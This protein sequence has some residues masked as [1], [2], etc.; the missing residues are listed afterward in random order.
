MNARLEAE[1]A[2]VA[3][4]PVGSPGNPR[5]YFLKANVGEKQFLRLYETL[6]KDLSVLVTPP[7]IDLVDRANFYGSD[8]PEFFNARSNPPYCKVIVRKHYEDQSSL[9]E[10]LF[11]PSG[12]KQLL[13]PT[14]KAALELIEVMKK[15]PY[16]LSKGEISRPTYYLA[17]DQ[18]REELAFD[19]RI[20]D[21]EFV[22]LNLFECNLLPASHGSYIAGINDSKIKEIMRIDG[23]LKEADMSPAL[24]QKVA[25]FI[26]RHNETWIGVLNPSDSACNRFFPVIRLDYDR[27]ATITDVEDEGYD[28]NSSEWEEE[29]Y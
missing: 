26:S 28:Y 2:S 20:N 17:V 10:W 8:I 21:D 11:D 14:S 29:V 16:Q 3:A 27:F 25:A 13:F 12:K 23:S 18:S 24:R 7:V 15:E 22:W 4:Y 9:C 5:H 6:P 1:F 19:R